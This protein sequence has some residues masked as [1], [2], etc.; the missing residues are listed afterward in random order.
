MLEYDYYYN[1]QLQ[2]RPFFQHY[3]R[4]SC[5]PQGNLWV[6]VCVQRKYWFTA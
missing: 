3:S 6:I 4:L 2:N 1:F 5:V